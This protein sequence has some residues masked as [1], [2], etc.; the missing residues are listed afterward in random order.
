[1][2]LV[3]FPGS[4]GVPARPD[5]DPDDDLEFGDDGAGGKMS[6]LEHL[7]ELRRRLVYAILSVFV[8]FLVALF[9][10]GRIF[11]FVMRPLQ[12]ILP[13]GGRLVYT[14]PTEAFLLQLKVA[15]LAGLVLAAPFVIWQLWLFVAPGLYANEKRFAV[16]FVLA[17]S[18]C[19]IGGA[20]FSH[21][22]VFPTA[23]AFLAGFTTDYMEFLPKISSTFGLYAK[24][25][26]A[27]GIIFQMPVLVF[28]L[29]R[30]GVITAGFLVRHT[31]Y[32]VLIIF[33]VAAVI[34]PTGDPVNQ[35]LMAFPM[36]ALYGL[37]IGIA[38]V[39]GRRRASNE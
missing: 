24:M 36:I 25:L 9:F 34:S 19:F 27:F 3:P 20:A 7:D 15:A 4:K 1:M 31:K 8:G 21:F 32:A 23:W 39:S 30:M 28:A 29:S 35:A 2:A 17:S 38:W 18:I 6:F 37:S 14:E 12:Q 33:I 16:P 5:Y 22:I 11:A 13:D 10:I 26:L